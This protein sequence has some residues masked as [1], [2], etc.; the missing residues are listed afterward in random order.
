MD[1]CLCSQEKRNLATYFVVLMNESR[2]LQ[3]LEAGKLNERK[4]EQVHGVAELAK[5]CLNLKSEQR[6]SMK[7]VAA[8]LERLRGFE[9]H[10]LVQ[11]SSEKNMSVASEGVDAYDSPPAYDS[12]GDS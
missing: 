5:R 11:K 10:Q 7:E 2:L 8:E 9:R 1:E 3:I 6:P 4:M 12:H